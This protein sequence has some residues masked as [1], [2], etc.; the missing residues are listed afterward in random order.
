MLIVCAN[1]SNLLLARTARRQK[2]M[3][4]RSALGAGRPRLIRQMLTESLGHIVHRC[5]GA[6]LGLI[7]AVGGTNALAHQTAFLI[8]LL[9]SIGIDAGALAFTLLMAVA[10]GLIFGLVPALEAPSGAIHESLKDGSRGATQGRRSAWIRAAL[11]VSEIAFACVLMMVAGLLIRSF[12]HV[13][14]VP[15]GFH[16]ERALAMRIDPGPEYATRA[17]RNA[18]YDEALRRVRSVPGIEAAG[19]TDILPFSGSR[20]WSLGAKGHVYSKAQPPP[21]LFAS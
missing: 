3:A 20:T 6:A 8:P 10:T 14:D 12:L 7:L 2:E 18:Y 21:P 1:L 9:E 16:P 13:L 17:Q 15:L 5:C 11:V 19:L 4:I